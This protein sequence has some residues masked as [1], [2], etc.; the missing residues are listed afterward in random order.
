MTVERKRLDYVDWV[1]AIGIILICLGHLLPSG[2]LPKVVMYCFHVP[3]FA[4]VGGILTRAP[5]TF[6]DLGKKLIKLV[7]RILVPYTIWFWVFAIPYFMPEESIPAYIKT[8]YELAEITEKFFFL[9][10][11]TIWNYALWFVPCYFLVSVAFALLMFLARGN[12]IA[13]FAMS[14]ASFYGFA[15]YNINEKNLTVFG[16]ENFLGISNI[17]LLFGFVAL[18]YALKGMIEE[19]ISLR[20]KRYKNPFLYTSFFFFLLGIMAAAHLNSTTNV[21]KYPAGFNPI[22][23]MNGDYNNDLTF[24][25]LAIWLTVTFTVSMGLLPKFKPIEMLSA[26]TFF[27]MSTHYVVMLFPFISTGLTKAEWQLDM[28]LGFIECGITILC[29]MVL[30]FL[31]NLLAKRFPKVT[32]PIL[33]VLGIQRVL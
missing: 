11:S 26:S 8:H 27:V 22:S 13:S 9:E 4:F 1:K 7:T 25:L 32:D 33:N 2:C 20:E 24:L 12:R 28:K 6:L 10:G 15:Y 30:L 29:Y 19:L 16:H 23:V 17:M 14:V 5:R 21:K 31:L 3:I 18:G